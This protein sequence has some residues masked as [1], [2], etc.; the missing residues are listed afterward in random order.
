MKIALIMPEW[1][2]EN[3]YPPLGLAYIG[4]VLEKDRHNVKIFDLTLDR[5]KPFESKVEDIIRFSPDIVGISAMTHSYANALKTAQYLKNNTGA[6]I[7]FGGPHPTIM[8]DDVMKNSFVDFVVI[9]EGEE[10][11][12]KICQ[13]IK[14]R[15]F[16]NIDGL[17]YRE[18]GKGIDNKE[19]MKIIVQP[20]NNFIKNLDDIPFPARHLLR[21]EDYRLIDDHGN[22]MVTII[23]SRGCPYGCTYC[24]KGLFGRIY[25]QRN[26]K[27]IIEE[28][29]YCIDLGYNSFYFIDDLFTLNEKRVEELTNAI[30]TE[31]LNI[32]WQCL[33]RVNN[34]TKQ[35][36]EQMKETGCY[37]VH[38]GIES[39]NQNVLDKVKKGI[40]LDQVRKAVKYCKEASIKTKGYFMIGMPGDNLESM[41][42]T[43]NL[44]KELELN[45]AMFSVTT[46]FPGT[47]LWKTIDKSKID[48]LSNA[49][50]FLDKDSS[51]NEDFHIFYN[52]SDVSN[53]E[54]IKMMKKAQNITDSI[55]LKIF[56]ERRFGK[57]IGPIAW[58]LS[59]VSIFRKTGRALIKNL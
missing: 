24:Y 51:I 33:A 53:E 55:G 14:S 56:C 41:N 26:P 35:M 12:L 3:P 8:P 34:A 30:K 43:L 11:F 6:S 29:K 45:E 27:N 47:D 23:S 52:L 38:F 42:D 40:T 57:R 17:C 25:R 7:I 39:G 20:K 22:R 58:Q 49:F 28:I 2:I 1:K 37:K 44:A 10:T 32:R 4:A 31:G 59:K 5:D 54:I 46:P 48:S 9:G 16:Q 50:Y 21:L 18:K 36:F 15:E 13:N 19:N